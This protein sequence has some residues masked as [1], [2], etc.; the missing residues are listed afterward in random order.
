VVA[1]WP[2]AEAKVMQDVMLST[3]VKTAALAKAVA[4]LS[5]RLER[6]QAVVGAAKAKLE[7]DQA[8]L[9]GTSASPNDAVGEMRA[10]ECRT[11]FARLDSAQQIAVVHTALDEAHDG[12]D[13]DVEMLAAVLNAP[14]S[15]RSLPPGIEKRVRDTLLQR[16]NPQAV[17]AQRDISVAVQVAGFALDRVGNDIAQR[18]G[19]TPD[20]RS[21]FESASALT[22]NP[23]DLS[24]VRN[25]WSECLPFP[26]K[27]PRHEAQ[28]FE[29]HHG[30][31]TR[32]VPRVHRAGPSQDN[33]WFCPRS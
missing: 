6:V 14:R 27:A 29:F 21:R 11:H 22:T 2:A 17:N 24:P 5:T 32:K 25:G 23:R 16:K 3:Q 33:S 9:I 13:G 7:P 10:I 4:E 31:G 28:A 18:A 19:I 12:R 20:P 26:C 8:I 15:L 1:E 30:P